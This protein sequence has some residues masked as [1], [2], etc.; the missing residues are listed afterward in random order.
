MPDKLSSKAETSTTTRESYCKLDFWVIES[1]KD[2][3]YDEL[4]E[5][6]SELG[7]Y[8]KFLIHD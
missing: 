6:E 8:S 5:I 7:R 4:F 3:K 2:Q 1:V